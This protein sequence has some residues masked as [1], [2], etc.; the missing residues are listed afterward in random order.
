MTPSRITPRRSPRNHD[1]G[2]VSPFTATLNQMMSEANSQTQSPSRN[3]LD[4]V[5][6]DFDHLP[7]LPLGNHG[8]FDNS[9]SL[10]DFFSTDVPMPSSPPRAFKLYEDPISGLNMNSIDWNEFQNFGKGLS[11]G[12][13][14]SDE[15]AVKKEPEPS[16]QKKATPKKKGAK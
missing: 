8:S 3:L 12:A 5:E 13:G 9:F 2:F 7:D 6:L 16:P 11:A 4:G 1:G 15:V 14:A 10:E